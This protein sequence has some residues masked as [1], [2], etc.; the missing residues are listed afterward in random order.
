[1]TD[2]LKTLAPLRDAIF[3]ACRELD[4]APALDGRSDRP[5]THCGM[6]SSMPVASSTA[7]RPSTDEATSNAGRQPLRGLTRPSS[8]NLECEIEGECANNGFAFVRIMLVI[9]AVFVG[10]LGERQCLRSCS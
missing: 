2:H 9:P 7:P 4:S 1:M 3:D 5:L 6:R 10:Q 8:G